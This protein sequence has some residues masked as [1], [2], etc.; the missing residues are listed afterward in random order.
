MCVR[1]FVRSCVRAFVIFLAPIRQMKRIIPGLRWHHERMN[2]QG[3]PDGLSGD[4]I[5]LMARIIAIADTFDAVTTDRPY[6]KTMTADEALAALD[7]HGGVERSRALAAEL[8]NVAAA[9]RRAV[10]R[11][12]GTT[13]CVVG[14][15]DRLVDASDRE[16]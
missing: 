11:G 10:R 6:Q 16:Q 1:A 3:Y 12:D 2:G 4:Q 8:E 13:A 7:S 14:D 9:C 5:P 15:L